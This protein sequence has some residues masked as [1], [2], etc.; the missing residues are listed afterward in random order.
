MTFSTNSRV[1][2]RLSKHLRAK[3][4]P[5]VYGPQ[6]GDLLVMGEADEVVVADDVLA[7]HQERTD[8]PTP[9]LNEAHGHVVGR[10][11]QASSTSSTFFLRTDGEDEIPSGMDRR[12]RA[13]APGGPCSTG[14]Q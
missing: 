14:A 4:S 5:T 8:V 9:V 10:S 13:W 12:R 2:R 3:P 1:G 7:P 11:L 6:L